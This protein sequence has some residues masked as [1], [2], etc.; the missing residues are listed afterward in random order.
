[1]TTPHRRIIAD[2]KALLETNI[3]AHLGSGEPYALLD[4]PN[5][6]NVGDSA[7]WLGESALLE[8]R[9]GTPPAYVS[10]HVAFDEEA[11]RT[12]CPDGPIFINGGGN[13]GDI[14]PDHQRFREHLLRIFPDRK[15]VQLPQS[16]RFQSADG[17]G[18]FASLVKSHGNFTLFVR[19]SASLGIAEDLDITA[20][21]SPDVV[22]GLGPLARLGNPDHDVVALLRTDREASTG[23]AAE[24]TFAKVKSL[25]WPAEPSAYGK[26]IW[27]RR[28]RRSLFRGRFGEQARR[29]DFMTH[30]ATERLNRGLAILSGGQVVVTDRLHGHILSFL[31]EIPHVILDNS[32]G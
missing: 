6:G 16:I 5:H 13:L 30:I 2:Q 1:M 27:R 12:A 3:A 14:W 9:A 20:T 18:M 23:D 7:I 22:F 26:E 11:L 21:L 10:T 25:D 8:A 29:L 4:F 24:M 17:A 28:R 32:A 31:L 15:I 19:D